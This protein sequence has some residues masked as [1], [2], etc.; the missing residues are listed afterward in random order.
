LERRPKG[1]GGLLLAYLIMAALIIAL[2]ILWNRPA[3]INTEY[4]DSQLVDDIKEDLVKSVEIYQNN[5]VPTGTVKVL[6]KNERI[7][8]Y[9]ND[10]A[11][12]IKVLKKNGDVEYRLYDVKRPGI[13]EKIAPYI[14][15]RIFGIS[16]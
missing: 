9:T 11:D 12:T 4:N 14:F 10:V 8:Y 15:A 5:E 6:K 16:F 2:Y 7:T 1:A 13:V 3:D